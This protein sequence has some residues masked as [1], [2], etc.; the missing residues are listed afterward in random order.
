MRYLKNAN[1]DGKRVI[2]R[3]DLNV[4]IV[5]GTIMDEN[6][7][8]ETLPTL[9][10]VLKRADKVIILSHLGRIKNETDLITYT[11]KPICKRLSELLNVDIGFCKYDDNIEKQILKN[12]VVMLEN[13]RYFD[14]YGGKES[15]NDL[16]LS[17]Y[18]SSFGDVFVNDAFGVCHRN[19]ASVVGITKFLPSYAGFLIEKEITELNKIKYNPKRPFS[20]I[21][22]GSKVSDKIGLISNLI[23]KVDNLIIVG[24][25]AFTF[26]KSENIDVGKSIIDDSSLNFARELLS[27]YSNKIILPIDVCTSLNIDDTESS[28][29]KN[30]SDINLN[31]IAFDIGPKTLEIIYSSVKNSKTIFLN[32]PA[33]AYEYDKFSYGTK[34]IFEMLCKIDADIIIGGGD[35]GA[36]AIKFGFKDKFKHISTGGGA[37]LEYLEGKKL[38]GI[39]CLCEIK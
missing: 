32:G 29:Y 27:K 25:M 36:A 20:I 13:T 21:L 16:S 10:Y 35:S 19:A 6:R 38:P 11:L 9:K 37:S 39:E 30:I 1:I 28:K 4:P 23:D 15:N 5:N 34:K 12:K 18:L 31:E 24:A 26:L 3:C 33:G 2:V 8:I 17:K 22:G 14:L 7:I